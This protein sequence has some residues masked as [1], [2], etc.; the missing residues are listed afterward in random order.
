MFRDPAGRRS[1]PRFPVSP[2]TLIEINKEGTVTTAMVE[3]ISASGI[4]LRFE[5]PVTLA[6]GEWVTLDF[7]DK[8]ENAPPLPYWGVGRVIRIDGLKVA[9][10]LNVS[11]LVDLDSTPASAVPEPVQK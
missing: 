4:L 8:V 6:L 2:G 1:E 5:V 7:V 11:G 9:M 10:T 3:N